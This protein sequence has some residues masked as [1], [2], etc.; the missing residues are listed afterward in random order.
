MGE[1]A[2]D[3]TGALA[4]ANDEKRRG[5]MQGS[6]VLVLRFDTLGPAHYAS[7]AIAGMFEQSVGARAFTRSGYVWTTQRQMA[8]RKN[9]DAAPDGS[10]EPDIH[11]L[12]DFIRA[13]A[14]W[15]FQQ[16]MQHRFFGCAIGINRVAGP[17]VPGV[18]GIFGGGSGLN[19]I[20]SSAAH[21]F[22]P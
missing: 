10:V 6:H 9:R 13:S 11:S 2:G 4:M 7:R 16:Y 3:I 1:V 17:K 14:P 15:A 5:P 21:S 20:S 22:A 12:L 8:V 19:R 18:T